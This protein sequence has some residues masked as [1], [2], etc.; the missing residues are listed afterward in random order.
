MFIRI[1]QNSIERGKQSCFTFEGV[2]VIS[3]G[4]NDR[5]KHKSKANDTKIGVV[6][7]GKLR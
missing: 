7:W 6:I 3:R 2:E 4:T 5:E 1:A